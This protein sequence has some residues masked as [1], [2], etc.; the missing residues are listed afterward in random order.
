M[1]EGFFLHTRWSDFF[2]S[3]FGVHC[4]E[5]SHILA[6]NLAFPQVHHPIIPYFSFVFFL[7]ELRV[8]LGVFLLLMALFGYQGLQYALTIAIFL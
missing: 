6:H 8:D 3:F 2:A 4:Q 1:I 5:L 7:L